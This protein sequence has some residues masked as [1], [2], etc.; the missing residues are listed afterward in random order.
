MKNLKNQGDIV[1]TN[2][3]Q[4][5]S[6]SIKRITKPKYVRLDEVSQD[7]MEQDVKLEEDI[8]HHGY[9][10]PTYFSLIDETDV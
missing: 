1:E 6:N 3:Y 9:W 8:T 5:F 10:N 4:Q 7:D 2:M